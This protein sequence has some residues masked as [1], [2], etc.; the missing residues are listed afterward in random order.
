MK[1]I[2]L[3]V[4]LLSVPFGSATAGNGGSGYSRFG[5]GD[6]QY[7]LSSRADGMGG[8]GIAV[9]ST[10]AIDR[11]NPAAWTSIIRTRFS[12]GALYEGYST[13][14]GRQSGFFSNANFNG[15]M[16]ALPLLPSHGIV[17]G[18]GIIPY[19]TINYYT[20][21]DTSQAGLKYT[22]GYHGEGGTS[23]AQVGISANARDNLHVGAK[24]NYYFGTL[25]HTITQNFTNNSA[26]TNAE[27][28]RSV[29]LKGI[30]FSVGT[31][32]SGL[33]SLLKL[34]STCSFTVG[35][36]VS[37]T[38][39]LT[40]NEE[41]DL[42]Y[43]TANVVSHDTQSVNQG[44]LRIPLSFAVGISYSSNRFLVAS[45][46][47][48]QQWGTFDGSGLIV[49]M[50]RNSYRIGVGAERIALREASA[51]FLQRTAYRWGFF[52][53]STYYIVKNRPVNEAGVTAGAGFPIFF[54]TRLDINASYSFR[55][56]TDLQMQKDR[57]L[58]LSFTLSG[59][60][61]WFVR[62]PEE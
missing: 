27:D 3:L 40:S 31:V 9:L 30:G 34:D 48:F 52:Y 43:T 38:S 25:R 6:I 47:S 53:N 45:D 36:V 33:N 54:D 61:I 17:L 2:P 14:D 62:F 8:T 29:Q 46:V 41:H 56:T 18:A 22:L 37:T 49:P 15:F 57:I 7:F 20:S 23:E 1:R 51:T 12:V 32:Y 26:Y 55:G 39:S 10:N 5:I 35:L 42:T 19:S 16:L 44:H 60:E 21:V 13:T 24:F 11:S 59:G 50:N 4:L 58:R 28:L